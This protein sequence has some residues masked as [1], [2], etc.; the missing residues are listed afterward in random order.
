M[1][2]SLSIGILESIFQITTVPGSRE[3]KSSS[4]VAGLTRIWICV[5]SPGAWYPFSESL[6]MYH[7]GR[8]EIF[9]G[10][11]FLPLTGIPMSNSVCKRIRFA[12][13]EPVPFAVAI[14]IVKSFTI[15]SISACHLC[16][17]PDG[18]VH[19]CPPALAHAL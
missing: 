10:N 18:E 7:V 1:T 13:C 15:F 3:A 8:P 4:H 11:R 2:S 9:E 12:D 14:F 5:L 19:H 17:P 6:T 16:S